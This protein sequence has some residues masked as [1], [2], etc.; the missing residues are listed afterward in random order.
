MF[1]SQTKNEVNP[2]WFYP[3]CL[4]GAT[5]GDL[6]A[7]WREARVVDRVLVRVQHEPRQTLQTALVPEVTNPARK[8]DG[9]QYYKLIYCYIV[10]G[11][12]WK[13][14]TQSTYSFP[15]LAWSCACS[16]ACL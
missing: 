14:Y 8:S 7:V 3:Q 5:R 12:V 4:A 11:R 2:A 9:V 15:L 13:A 16:K 6:A 10:C 1:K